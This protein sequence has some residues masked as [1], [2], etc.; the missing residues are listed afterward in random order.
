MSELPINKVIQ[1]DNIH[2]LGTF[3]DNCI[4]LTVTSPP[5]D[6]LR[7]YE[8]EVFKGWIL[9]DE[10]VK[11]LYRVTKDGGVVVWVVGD[12]TDK[13][14]EKGTPFRHALK[15]MEL[16]F[17]L[18]D[19]MIYQKNGNVQ[20]TPKSHRRYHQTFEYMFIFSKGQP[21]T[22]NPIKDRRNVSGGTRAA[23]HNRD[24][25]GNKY[26]SKEEGIEDIW[27][28]Y[29]GMRWN[30]WEYRTGASGT[31]KDGDAYKHVAIFPD[32]LAKDHILSWSNPGDI[33]LDPFLGSG[34]TAKQAYI[35]GRNWVGIELSK[36][37]VE[38][39]QDRMSRLQRINIVENTT[40]PSKAKR[41]L[42]D[43]GNFDHINTE[44][45]NENILMVTNRLEADKKKNEL[46]ERT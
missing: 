7:E 12:K 2:V 36:E 29:M 6:D 38:V 15:F 43:Y 3:P 27:I 24:S 37:Y 40:I 20:P 46:A 21:K 39:F 16:G 5:Y 9:T 10:L 14:S 8:R 4:D 30:V 25:K 34:T 26:N 32:C 18:H 19:T 11:Q 33:V 28:E 22:F 35:L 31:T 44:W 45:S 41:R 17:K 13:G 42:R 23:Y 1:G